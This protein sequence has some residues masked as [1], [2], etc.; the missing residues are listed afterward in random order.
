MKKLAVLY[1]AHYEQS[2]GGAEIQ[3][4]YLMEVCVR[5]GIE[6]HYIFVNKGTEIKNEL[7]AILYPL[8]KKRKY[9]F[10]GQGWFL[11]KKQIVEVLDKINP[12]V[13]YTRLGSSWINIASEYALKHRIKHIHALASDKD[14]ARKILLP[15]F[16]LY[17][18]KLKFFI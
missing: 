13:I 10:C 8:N 18:L 3:I 6:V 12:D 14:V 1:P 4:R 15:P 11:Y 2:S 7:R 9:K 17:F 16:F 5:A